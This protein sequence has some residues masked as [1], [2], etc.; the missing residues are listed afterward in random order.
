MRKLDAIIPGIVRDAK[1]ARA[2]GDFQKASGLDAQVQKYTLIRG[3]AASKAVRFAKV[4]ALGVVLTQQAKLQQNLLVAARA[5]IAKNQPKGARV[6]VG[7]FNQVAASTKGLKDLRKAQVVK[8]SAQT[9]AAKVVLASKLAAQAKSRLAMLLRNHQTASGKKQASLAL[10]ISQHQ[11]LVAKLTNVAREQRTIFVGQAGRF[12]AMG[13]SK[14]TTSNPSEAMR[15]LSSFELGH[16]MGELTQPSFGSFE[17]EPIRT[18]N[19]KRADGTVAGRLIND[20]SNQKKYEGPA[21]LSGSA[22]AKFNKEAAKNSK[23]RTGVDYFS[24]PAP[25]EGNSTRFLRIHYNVATKMIK[26][27]AFRKGGVVESIGKGVSDA[28]GAVKDA[29]ET[30]GRAAKNLLK[31]VAC[32]IGSNPGVL[33]AAG[34]AIGGPVGGKADMVAGVLTN[35]CPSK[36]EAPVDPF[37]ASSSDEDGKKKSLALPIAVGGA[38]LLTILL[39]AL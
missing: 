5:A 13:K 20:F 34:A 25:V 32:K 10:K 31:N 17:A 12:N 21:T 14:M 24:V 9:A 8:S 4:Q 1:R 38:G 7:A 35:A 19:R 27:N 18:D 16:A 28:A 3:M 39:V 37:S 22:L 6:L 23:V 2:A 33:S 15:G 26:I 30:A 11:A 29:V 36:P